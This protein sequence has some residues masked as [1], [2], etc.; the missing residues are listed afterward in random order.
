M[1]LFPVK[2][3]IAFEAKHFSASLTWVLHPV[4]FCC[5]SHVCVFCTSIVEG[6]ITLVA[7]VLRGYVLVMIFYVI[8]Q[9]AGGPEAEKA[10]KIF[11]EEKLEESGE[12][13]H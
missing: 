7:L 12:R 11:L 3:K 9:L 2:F 10:N 5:F 8:P 4:S 13:Q 6:G 1:F